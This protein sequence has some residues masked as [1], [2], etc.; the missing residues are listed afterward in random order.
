M[1]RVRLP[2]YPPCQVAAHDRRQLF[3]HGLRGVGQRHHLGVAAQVETESN[4]R[5]QYITI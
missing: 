2:P 4:R 1:S 3:E 5:K